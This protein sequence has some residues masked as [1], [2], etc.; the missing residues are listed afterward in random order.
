ML[1]DIKSND[2]LLMEEVDEGCQLFF[3]VNQFILRG[4]NLL[5]RDNTLW[6]FVLKLG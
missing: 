3:R 6:A 4:N 5:R 1:S 2:R